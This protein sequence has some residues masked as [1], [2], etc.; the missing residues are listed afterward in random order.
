MATDM[1]QK[2]RYYMTETC[3]I[4]VN[5][6]ELV[7]GKQK[8][9]LK[10]KKWK[11]MQCLMERHDTLVPY[12][13]ILSCVWP[14]E[15]KGRNSLFTLTFRLKHDDFAFVGLTGKEMDELLETN[16]GEGIIL[17]PYRAAPVPLEGPAK[18]LQHAGIS[19]QEFSEIK[20]CLINVGISGRMGRERL[21]VLSEKGNQLASLELG[22]LY[23]YG[24][25]TRNH[26]RD[27]KTAC[28]YYKKAGDHPVALWTLGYCIMNNY[29][30]VVDP[31]QIDYGAARDYFVR[32]ESVTRETGVLAAAL[33]SIGVLWENGHYPCDDFALTRRCEKPNMER[34]ISY[35]RQADQMGYHYATNRLGLYYE[36]RGR[37]PRTAN[38]EDLKRAFDYFSR[39]VDLVTDGYA[40]N[41]L[42]QYYEKGI[43]CQVNADKACECYIRGIEEPLADD[44]TGWN[45]F[46]AG[47]VYANRIS[48]QPKR[49]YHL[50]RAF[51]C[52]DQALR[53]LPVSEHAKILLEM[54]DILILGYHRMTEPM[55]TALLVQT[56]AWT[57]Q[58]L[59]ENHLKPYDPKTAEVTE[60][61]KKALDLES[62]SHTIQ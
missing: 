17:R 50:S 37:H 42:G 29:Y 1:Q 34:A 59:N 15:D 16:S 3:Y 41:K 5:S 19:R 11:L 57:E 27:Y 32:A 28:A 47:R 26:E 44:M 9:K 22:E 33:T 10:G 30:P 51:E 56:K 62:Y 46:N 23:F 13:E 24:Y 31:E 2:N 55:R 12:E 48:H 6:Q 60:I 43:G 45:Y 20:D 25:I 49:Y 38:E 7:N 39:S 35:Y 21:I 36:K 61:R 18:G 40:L 58:Y 54:L 4:D 8:T 14:D 52:F 53:L